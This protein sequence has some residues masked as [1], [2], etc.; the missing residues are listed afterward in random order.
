M[1]SPPAKPFA[2]LTVCH[3]NISRS[4]AAQYLLRA[5]LDERFRIT[6]AG[7]GAYQVIGWDADAQTLALLAA[8]GIDA[9]AHRSRQ[10][11]GKMIESA[12]LI[13]TMAL[14]Q[15]AW[16]VE[17]VPTAISRTFTLR[18]FARL[19][20]ALHGEQP[21]S[22]SSLVRQAAKSRSLYPVADGESDDIDDPHGRPPAAYRRA[23]DEISA[24]VSTVAQ[25][26]L[27]YGKLRSKPPENPF[28]G[29]VLGR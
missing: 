28:A 13:L 1:T 21:K 22:I 23:F 10:L 19:A 5:K 6:S 14:E 27:G 3:G 24:A 12:E 4:P 9:S 25:E 11:T 15:R 17:E 18:E 29:F 7:T 8:Q 2:I 16:I 26:L 20:A